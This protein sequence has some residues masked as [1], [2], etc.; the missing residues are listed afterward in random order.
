MTDTTPPS[1]ALNL[2]DVSRLVLVPRWSGDASSDY[3][4]WLKRLA[5]GLTVEV[6]PLRPVPN[7][8]EVEP[9]VA[10]LLEVLGDDPELLSR[11]LVLAHSVGCQAAMRALARLGPGQAVR[12]LLCVAGWWTVDQPWDL[13]VPWMQPFDHDAVAEHCSAVRV[14]VSDNDPYTRDW[15][16]T[17][18]LFEE[19]VGATVTVMPGAEHLNF[20]TLPLALT[21]LQAMATTPVG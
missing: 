5:T 18:R 20:S 13:I 19:R 4:P 16:E 9:T 17:K 1:P 10:A 8:P 12:G 6:S 2:A 21:E 11:T 7:T 14:L 15:R 3:F